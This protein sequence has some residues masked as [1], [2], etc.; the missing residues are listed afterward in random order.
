PHLNSKDKD[1][2]CAECKTP[3]PSDTLVLEDVGV[4]AGNIYDGE[5]RDEPKDNSPEEESVGVNVAEEGETVLG[6]VGVEAEERAADRLEL[7]GR[8]QNQPGKLG[9]DSATSTEDEITTIVVTSVT[10][11]AEAAV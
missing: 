9:K 8:E 3:F 7:P 1:G 2:D 4:E 6:L 5:D 11:A 10:S